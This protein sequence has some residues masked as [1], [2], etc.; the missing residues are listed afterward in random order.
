M[1][2]QI[3]NVQNGIPSIDQIRILEEWGVDHNDG[4]CLWANE[5]LFLF[6]GR[7]SSIDCN[8]GEFSDLRSTTANSSKSNSISLRAYPNPTSDFCVVEF[9]API[10]AT[11]KLTMFDVTGKAMEFW[12][13]KEGLMQQVISLKTVPIGYY[14]FH[15]Y[16]SADNSIHHFQIVKHD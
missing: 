9:E 6:T 11:Y 7:H 10:S 8:D 4:T 1:Q 2:N 5:L 15:L 16:D 3:F 13:L 14:I 12:Q